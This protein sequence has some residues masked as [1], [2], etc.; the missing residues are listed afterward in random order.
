MFGKWQLPLRRC[1]GSD[2][3]FGFQALVGKKASF[4]ASTSRNTLRKGRSLPLAWPSDPC[5]G[6]LGGPHRPVHW[7]PRTGAGRARPRCL[8]DASRWCAQASPG[9]GGL[10]PPS[11]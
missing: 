5:S 6:Q 1:G 2:I 9:C 11:Q 7:P 10:V 8:E 4:Q 3:K